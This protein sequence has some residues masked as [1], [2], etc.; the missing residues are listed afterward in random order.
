MG[1]D[2]HHLSR[3]IAAG[4]LIVAEV[5]NLRLARKARLRNEKATTAAAN[6]ALFGEGKAARQLREAESDRTARQL[7]GAKRDQD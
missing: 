3:A 2:R 7:D 5:I 6:R 1:S 4:R